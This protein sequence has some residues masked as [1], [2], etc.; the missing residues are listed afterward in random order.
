MRGQRGAGA[1]SDIVGRGQRDGLLSEKQVG[2]LK[3]IHLRSQTA[4]TE[5]LPA[6]LQN[7]S[8]TL[9]AFK[10][11]RLSNF[12]TGRPELKAE[13]TVELASGHRVWTRIA[14][15][16]NLIS[17]NAL[18]GARRI[19]TAGEQ[20]SF[21]ASV[22]SQQD[23]FVVAKRTQVKSLTID[24]LAVGE[25]ANN[26]GAGIYLNDLEAY[27]AELL[28]EAKRYPQLFSA[29]RRT[30]AE[31][32]RERVASGLASESEIQQKAAAEFAIRHPEFAA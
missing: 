21:R 30:V 28:A 13:I 27:Y 8:G 32:I 31:I 4:P 24:G 18:A 1:A 3:A 29:P 6:G 16:D 10:F 11:K 23:G 14:T 12:Q 9:V 7:I 20:V 26:V 22:E 19:P 5:L 25:W 2:F 17:L 15:C